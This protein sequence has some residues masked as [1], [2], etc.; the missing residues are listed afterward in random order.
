MKQG[1]KLINDAL[2]SIIGNFSSE[3]CLKQFIKLNKFQYFITIL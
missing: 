3:I 1:M 2:L